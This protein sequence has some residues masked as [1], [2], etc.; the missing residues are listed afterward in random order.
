MDLLKVLT[1]YRPLSIFPVKLWQI[2]CREAEVCQLSP[3]RLRKLYLQLCIFSG[4][5]RGG[6]NVLKFLKGKCGL[7]MLSIDSLALRLFSTS[8]IVEVIE[9]EFTA[10]SSKTAKRSSR[11]IEGILVAA[12]TWPTEPFMVFAGFPGEGE[13]LEALRN[14]RKGDQI[15]IE[16]FGVVEEVRQGVLYVN[17]TSDP[18]AVVVVRED[19]RY[20]QALNDARERAI[21]VVQKAREVIDQRDYCISF[22]KFARRSIQFAIMPNEEIARFAVSTLFRP[23]YIDDLLDQLHSGCSD[24]VTLTLLRTWMHDRIKSYSPEDIADFLLYYPI[25]LAPL[26]LIQKAIHKHIFGRMPPQDASNAPSTLHDAWTTSARRLILDVLHKEDVL[27]VSAEDDH[28]Y[29]NQTPLAKQTT[30]ASVFVPDR[31]S[32]KS[33][34]I[35]RSTRRNETSIPFFDNFESE[36]PGCATLIPLQRSGVCYSCESIVKT[37][38]AERGGY[39]YAFGVLEKASGLPLHNK[40]LPT[41]PV[42]IEEFDERADA[43]FFYDVTMGDSTW[44]LP[45]QIDPEAIIHKLSKQEIN[46]MKKRRRPEWKRPLVKHNATVDFEDSLEQDVLDELEVDNSQAH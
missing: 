39:H 19:M 22:V 26:L 23:G 1:V 20:T 40:L 10:R 2:L 42:Y 5:N 21:D 8:E 18:G 25:F 9:I 7:D 43:T 12:K 17:A 3:K 11:E 33:S 41:V 34:K 46:Q 36:C 29:L 4:W 6:T 37:I 16:H 38:L 31:K 30:S 27:R 32:Q 28:P 15:V 14:L 13:R 35:G 45:N 24:G 44:K